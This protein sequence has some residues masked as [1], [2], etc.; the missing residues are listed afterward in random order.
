MTWDGPDEVREA[1][2]EAQDDP[3]LRGGGVGGR[4]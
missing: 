4:R 1:M 3:W 2:D